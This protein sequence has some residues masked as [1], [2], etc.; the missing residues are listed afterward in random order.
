MVLVNDP[1]S[2]NDPGTPF[3]PENMNHI[4]DGIE[5][6]HIMI[7]EES[8]AR[9]AAD[10]VVLNNTKAYTDT[11]VASAVTASQFWLPAVD[12]VAHLPVITD[13]SKNWLCRVRAEQTV[14]QCV[15]GQANWAP[16]SD[17]TDLVN[18]V[19]LAT[20]ISGHNQNAA[21]HNDI[22]GTISNKAQAL[23]QAIQDLQDQINMLMPEGLENL[24]E[25][26]ANI[27]ALIGQRAPKNHASTTTDYGAANGATYGHVRFP[28]AASTTNI[29]KS[30]LPY[31]YIGASTAIDL[32]T[33]LTAGVYVFYNPS[34]ASAN[35]PANW[36][37]GTTN[38]AI[39]EVLPFYSS[40]VVRQ[41]L[42]KRGTNQ[43]W[44]RYSTS[45]SAWGAWENFSGKAP[46]ASPELTGTPTA[47]TAGAKNNSAQ[48]AT[49]AYADRAGHPVGSYY[50]QYPVVG[51][52]T[53]ANMFPESKSPGTL[54]G[55]TW[56][57]L[58]VGEE[59]FFK[60]AP[61][62]VEANRGKTYNTSTK[63]W[64]GTG[65]TGIQ[66]DAIK[67]FAGRYIQSYGDFSGS[68]QG[69]SGYNG[70]FYEEGSTHIASNERGAEG[71]A[72]YDASTNKIGY[73]FDPSR[74]VP[75]DTTNH[76]KNRLIKVWEKT[77]A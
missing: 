10:I 54:F 1:G 49:T 51:Q 15:A 77:A 23:Q 3:S 57:E 72:E 33:Y 75:I 45:A 36:G 31:E 58:F 34:A 43:I 2:I 6:A 13:T 65:T 4:E 69:P 30:A 60:T 25:L 71:V 18:E 66:G 74:V 27:E 44:V 70:P 76:P 73:S 42:H 9:A 46:L 52:S 59:V 56:T 48:I 17:K 37:T 21:A 11:K 68:L 19:E 7:A 41:I 53:I 35:F 29:P 64:S 55:G 50:T 12:T 38:A 32:N 62:T 39:L 20:A 40:T 5:A 22:R 67:N 24:P 16:Y 61:S 26:L 8:E 28:T 47:P 14:Y 63:L